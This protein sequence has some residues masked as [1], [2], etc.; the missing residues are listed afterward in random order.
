MTISSLL[1][2]MLTILTVLGIVRLAKGVLVQ[3]FLLIIAWLP[4][5]VV[6]SAVDTSQLK[7]I[8]PL[9][10]YGLILFP[11]TWDVLYGAFK[12]TEIGWF[13]GLMLFTSYIALLHLSVMFCVKW[14][15]S[16][17][18]SPFIAYLGML[19]LGLGLINFHREVYNAYVN[20]CLSSGIHPL[21]PVIFLAFLGTI[22]YIMVWG[23]KKA[24]KP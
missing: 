24:D 14:K 19:C 22:I 9:K 16:P 20:G 5:I 8:L 1:I 11:Y 10:G 18:Y 4:S 2:L 6:T 7:T 23:T 15:M 17:F 21:M 3:S 13:A 12:G